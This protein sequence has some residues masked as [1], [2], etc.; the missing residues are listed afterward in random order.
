MVSYGYVSHN[1]MVHCYTTWSFC[2]GNT[3]TDPT[4]ISPFLM[5]NSTINMAIFNSFLYVYQAGYLRLA[6][7]TISYQN[8]TSN[9]SNGIFVSTLRQFANDS[10]G[11][12]P[13]FRWVSYF[14]AEKLHSKL[15]NY[16]RANNILEDIHFTMMFGGYYI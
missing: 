16:Q 6:M 7:L 3:E 15:W 9:E 5:G 14:D 13:F 8:W 10:C 4:I 11:K 12:R 2:W 1:Q